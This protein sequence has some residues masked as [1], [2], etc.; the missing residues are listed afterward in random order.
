MMLLNEDMTCN[1]LK[2]NTLFQ[3]STSYDQ[4]MIIACYERIKAEQG[5]SQ[6]WTRLKSRLNKAEALINSQWTLASSL[7]ND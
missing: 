1:K 2:M 5:W 7:R 6:G 3:I 4:S